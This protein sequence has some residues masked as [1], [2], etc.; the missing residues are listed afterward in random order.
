MENSLQIN[1]KLTPRQWKL[2]NLLASAI[3]PLT[4]SEIV[5]QL[6]DC[7]HMGKSNGG[8][9]NTNCPALYQDIHA[10]NA[11]TESDKIIVMNNNKFYF[12]T[13]EEAADY[14]NKLR[15]RALKAWKKYHDINQKISKDG[16]GKLISNHGDVITIKSKARMFV[17]SY[18]SHELEGVTDGD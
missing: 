2:H 3:V 9:H 18:V 15:I 17:E 1:H 14:A 12:A 16:Q 6:P 4:M 13:E 10:I 8:D 11:S 5:E 7:Y